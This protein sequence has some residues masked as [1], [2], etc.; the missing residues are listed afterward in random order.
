MMLIQEKIKQAIGILKEFDIDCWITFTRESQINGDPTL[1]FLVSAGLTWHS[2]LILCKDGDTRAIVGKYDKAMV[3][4]TGAYKEVVGYVEGVKPPLLEYLRSKNPAKI[5]L[6]YSK[7]SEICDGLTHGMYLTMH[8]ILWEIG[9]QDRI[10][11][12]EPIVSALRQRKSKTEIDSMKKAIRRTEEIFKKVEKF[13]APG[14]TEEQVAEFMRLAARQRGL[15]CA[16][17]PKVCPAV[18]SGP[19]TAGAHYNPTKCRIEPGHILNMDFGLK[20][21]GYCSDLQRTFYVLRP[22]EKSAPPDVQKGFETIVKSIELARQAM[23]PGVQGIEIDAI[24]RKTVVDAGYEEFP[25]ALGHQVGRFAHDGTAILGPAWEKYAKK[26]FQKLEEGM[27]FTLEPRLTVPGRGIATVENMVIV[28]KEGAE[29]IS[30]PQRKLILI[31]SRKTAVAQRAKRR[32]EGRVSQKRRKG[33][34]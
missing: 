10:V 6:N 17:E 20:V 18:F 8:D 9:F 19:D 31:Q 14:K 26:P 11:S 5:A 30:T 4:D 13:I 23:K 27:V 2:A 3:E 25:H 22:G 21:D 7:D 16:W 34:R 29:Y 32:G 28:T 15:E 33:S 12:A 1:S 24:S